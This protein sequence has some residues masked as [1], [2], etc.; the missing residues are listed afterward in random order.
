MR[1]SKR[2][3]AAVSPGRTTYSTSG[4]SQS[5]VLATGA[6]YILISALAPQTCAGPNVSSPT[7]KGRALPSRQ[8][9]LGPRL[10]M[11]FAK[12]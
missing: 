5:P 3:L 11:G 2:R 4:I 6:I 9:R 1:L 8:V 12:S 7:Q 10:L